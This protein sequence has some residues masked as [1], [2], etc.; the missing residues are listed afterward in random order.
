ME[1]GTKKFLKHFCQY[2][3]A[4]RKWV[5]TLLDDEFIWNEY[6]RAYEPNKFMDDFEHTGN[7]WCGKCEKEWT[8]G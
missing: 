3:G 1:Q 2:C 8:G 4:D 6:T 5:E 7:E